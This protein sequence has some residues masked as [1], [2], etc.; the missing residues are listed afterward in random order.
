MR[1]NDKIIERVV[2]LNLDPEN[3]IK[4]YTENLTSVL[5]EA[6]VEEVLALMQDGHIKHLLFSVGTRLGMFVPTL[7]SLARIYLGLRKKEYL[8]SGD[9]LQI[10]EEILMRYKKSAYT[11]DMGKKA[12]NMALNYFMD[13]LLEYALKLYK[14]RFQQTNEGQDNRESQIRR[15]ATIKAFCCDM[16]SEWCKKIAVSTPAIVNI[17][18]RFSEAADQFLQE[19]TGEPAVSA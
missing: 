15:H 8:S 11:E 13:Y 18:A 19:T 7:E 2:G 12:R 4:S 1:F 5:D 6:L 3:K 10:Q 9:R 16:I 14:E 17:Q